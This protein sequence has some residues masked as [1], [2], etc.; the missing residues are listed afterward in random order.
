MNAVLRIRIWGGQ[1]S[2]FSI[3]IPNPQHWMNDFGIN[4]EKPGI[5]YNVNKDRVVDR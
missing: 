5:I 2:R 4:H 3:N 1:K